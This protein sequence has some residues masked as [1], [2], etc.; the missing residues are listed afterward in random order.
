VIVDGV[1]E[2]PVLKIEVA[3]NR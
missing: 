2:R 1:T 3:A